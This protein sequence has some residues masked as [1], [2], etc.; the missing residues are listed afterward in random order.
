MNDFNFSLYDPEDQSPLEIKKKKKSKEVDIENTFNFDLYEPVETK[1]DQ[2]EDVEEGNSYGEIAKDVAQQG[3]KELAIGTLGTYGD[4][5]G[6]SGIK[7]DEQTPGAVARNNAE[8]DTLEKFQQPDY[9]PSFSDLYS[10]SD[11]DI[12][13]NFSGLPTSESLRS[14]NDSLGGPGEAKTIAGRYAGRSA[15]IAG[16]GAAFGFPGVVSSTLAG[17]AGQTVEELGGGVLGQS[18]AEI[19]ALVLSPKKGAQNAVSSVKKTV[20][21]KIN[22]L[23]KVGYTDEQITLAINEASRG[24]VL[25]VR[26][27]K[28]AKTEKAFENFAE[29]SDE[30]ISNILSSEVKGFEKGTKQIKDLAFEAYGEVAERSKN[31]KIKNREPFVNAVNDVGLEIMDNLAT[32]PEAA[33]FIKM[34]EEALETTKR[35]PTASAFI[36]FYKDLNAAG[37]WIPPKTKDRWITKIKNGIKRTFES[38][39]KEGQELTKDFE[40]VNKGVVKAYKAVDVHD[41]IQ[42]ATTQEGK[43]FSK[44]HKIFDKPENVKLF[45]DVLGATQTNNL[46]QISKVGKEVKDFDKAWKAVSS[47]GVD[48][49]LRT[50]SIYYMLM[51]G[52]WAKLA[53]VKG[54]ELSAK[55]LAEKSLTDPQFQNLLIKGLHSLKSGSAKSFRSV[56]NEVQEYLKDKKIE[57]PTDK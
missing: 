12:A 7:T 24:S 19:A 6:L 39:G 40:T 45:E 37:S 30:L 31:I 49:A 22:E 56:H 20:Q 11:D 28:T 8:F 2:K 33:A 54:A 25:G 38:G 18:A 47:S 21:S 17:A 42:K 14:L 1:K 13:P 26:A 10:L 36:N 52:D 35:D 5:I 41:L 27:S 51:A 9:Q 53:A 32:K 57:M 46:R 29:H 50:G 16:S 44:I 43:N 3:V 55:R 48:P 34:L 15:N 23:R 4:L